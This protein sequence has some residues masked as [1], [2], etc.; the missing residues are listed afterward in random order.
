M[1]FASK[2]ARQGSKH[3]LFKADKPVG[4]N[5]SNVGSSKEFGNDFLIP[6]FI[7]IGATIRAK[8]RRMSY[9]SIIRSAR[10][11]R[12]HTSTRSINFDSMTLASLKQQVICATAI[13][14]KLLIPGWARVLQLPV[15]TSS[16]YVVHYQV[17]KDCPTNFPESSLGK[18]QPRGPRGGI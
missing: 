1:G 13:C 9:N 6:E 18:V 12:A 11:Q 5:L 17:W 14:A 8:S 16:S 7:Q 2:W 15:Q 4:T 3:L 10:T